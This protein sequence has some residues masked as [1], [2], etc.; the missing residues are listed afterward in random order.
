MTGAESGRNAAKALVDS[1]VNLGV[2]RFFCV[3]GESYISVLD[4][5]YDD[6]VIRVVTCRHEAGAGFMA[7]ADAKASGRV[8]VAFASRGPGA[9]NAA[10]A[11]HAAEQDALPLVLFLGHV[12][13]DKLG[14][15]AFQE[16]DMGRTFG[17]IAK[18][19]ASNAVIARA[20]DAARTA[21]LEGAPLAQPLR[22]SGEFPPLVTTM[23]EVG[24]QSGELEAMLGKVAA[25]YD[26]Q[27]EN[28]LARLTA[29]LEPLLFLLMVG[30]V[31]VI[32]LA[33]LMPLLQITS[34]LN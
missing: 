11:L 4:C 12:S 13:R 7:L 15:G 1:L 32:I 21:I 31:L 17:D 6:P 27:V 10:I 20:V 25:A 33:T 26:E 34:S 16:I 29:L 30:I 2:D 22:N 3:P 24:E 18:H 28:T 8:G 5:L 19:V 14:R 9:A 23:L